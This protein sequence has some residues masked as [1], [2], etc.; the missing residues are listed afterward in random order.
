[1]SDAMTARHLGSGDVAVLGTPVVVQLIE[2]AAVAALEG[3][4][5][6]GQTTVGVAVRVRH[7]APTPVGAAVRAHATVEEVR[8]GR[9]QF[10]CEVS[11]PSGP[12]AE[13]MHAR[14]VVD[15]QRFEADAANRGGTS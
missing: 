13:A 4:V 6:D 5:P 2:R 1:M 15:R 11:D 7:R 8:G 14:V 3:K 12:V 10:S 9:I